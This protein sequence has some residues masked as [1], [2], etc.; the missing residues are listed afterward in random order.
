M[1]VDDNADL[2]RL[3]RIALGRQHTLLEA[4]NGR[5]AL[6]LMAIERPQIVLLDIMIPGDLGGL[7]V[8]DIIKRDPDLQHT[9]VAMLTSRGQASDD[10]DAR[11]RGAD[12]YFIKPFSPR[13]LKTWI[14]DRLS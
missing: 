1:I 6:A 9:V 5:R 7:Q 8:L 13:N 2:R 10:T 3:M 4:S 14:E 12:A 11:M